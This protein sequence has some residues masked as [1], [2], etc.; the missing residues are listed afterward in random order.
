MLRLKAASLQPPGSSTFLY[1]WT[2][3]SVPS[4]IFGKRPMSAQRHLDVELCYR[5]TE[6]LRVPISGDENACHVLYSNLGTSGYLLRCSLDVFSTDTLNWEIL[7]LDMPSA[8]PPLWGRSSTVWKPCVVAHS[9][10][11]QEQQGLGSCIKLCLDQS[12][13]L[14]G[15]RARCSSR[16]TQKCLLQSGVGG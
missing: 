2:M 15:L 8:V 6:L 14:V 3:Y 1:I 9:W 10:T 4:P 16:G 5:N 13:I 12:I 7:S 11:H